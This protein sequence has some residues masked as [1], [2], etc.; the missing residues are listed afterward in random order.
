MRIK[1]LNNNQ[2]DHVESNLGRSL[3][4]A[5]LA[6]AVGSE[7]D[8]SRLPR[9]GDF[10]PVSPTWEVCLRKT[11]T[12]REELGIKLTVLRT[13]YWFC[14][15][16]DNATR[17]ISWNGGFRWGSG[18]PHEIPKET[19]KEYTTRWKQYAKQAE[20]GG[21]DLRAPASFTL[22]EHNAIAY[23]SFLRAR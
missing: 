10:R 6:V 4:R 5:G 23:A 14:G 2:E 1:Y 19:L 8:N 13:D 20:H 3:I 9:P 15:H 7:T 12:G 22:D 17:K 18:L 11:A 21:P 16:P